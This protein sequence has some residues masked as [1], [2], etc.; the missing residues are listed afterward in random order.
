MH[1][2]TVGQSDVKYGKQIEEKLGCKHTVHKNV[3]N[4]FPY[5]LTRPHVPSSDQPR[6]PYYDYLQAFKEGTALALGCRFL[7]VSDSESDAYVDLPG[8]SL[9]V[10]R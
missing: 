3:G 8:T 2:Y 6:G 9:E 10:D 7:V 4:W 5:T 1:T